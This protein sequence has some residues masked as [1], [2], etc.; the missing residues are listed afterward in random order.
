MTTLLA[1]KRSAMCNVEQTGLSNVEQ[2][3]M[4]NRQV[5]FVELPN[6]KTNYK[7]DYTVLLGKRQHISYIAVVI[8]SLKFSIFFS[9][10]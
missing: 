7:G 9:M 1:L 8:L 3:V 5:F 4:L 6:D 10:F 2:T